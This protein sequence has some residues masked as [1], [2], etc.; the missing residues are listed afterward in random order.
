MKESNITLIKRVVGLAGDIVE[1]RAGQI[2]VNGVRSIA[3]EYVSFLS[4]S[5]TENLLAVVPPR[6]IYVLGDNR[7]NSTDSRVFGPVPVTA[8][9]GVVLFRLWR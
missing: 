2:Y 9:E 4:I 5:L 3:D 6:C 8:I 7:A 1:I